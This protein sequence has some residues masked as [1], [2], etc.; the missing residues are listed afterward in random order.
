MR[1][2]ALL[3]VAAIALC[4]TT[5]FL[6]SAAGA[7]QSPKGQGSTKTPDI[8]GVW[9]T[10]GK[11][12]AQ[13][14]LGESSPML[15]WAQ[16]RMKADQ[17]KVSS[18]VLCIPPG[19]P[20]IWTQPYPFEIISL[21]GRVLIYY[22]FQHF[23]RDIRTDGRD[24]PKDLLPTYMG[25][26]VGKWEGDTLVVDTIGF[27]D[28]TSLDNVRRPHSDALHVIERIRRRTHDELQ[29]DITI[30]DPKAYT[31][32]WSAQRIYDLKPGWEISEQICED[33]N[34][35]LFPPDKAK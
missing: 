9:F 8:S 30:D 2:R 17:Q 26:S 19:V 23:L 29:L 24:H 31:K 12:R 15:P 6:A 28:I 34:T 22:E 32:P 33:N 13:F 20:R 1:H 35:Y 27:N 10:Q 14:D 4:C 7:P 16:D 21:P 11:V 3:Q 25:N 5:L 18:A